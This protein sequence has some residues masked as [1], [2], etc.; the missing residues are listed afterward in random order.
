MHRLTLIL[1]AA[2]GFVT[3][4]AHAD[5][6]TRTTTGTVSGFDLAN[7]F[8]TGSQDLEGQPFSLVLHFDDTVPVDF[9]V[10]GGDPRDGEFGEFDYRGGP[11][12]GQ[13]IDMWASLTLG[14]RS[15]ALTGDRSIYGS[16][17]PLRPYWFLTDLD[18][19]GHALS[20]TITYL[21][22]NF[23][24]YDTTPSFRPIAGG[25]FNALTFDQTT[26]PGSY[27][28]AVPE[29]SEWAMLLLGFAATG[30]TLR[31]RTALRLR[32]SAVSSKA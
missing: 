29:L 8:G 7:I 23:S 26:T 24:I 13:S 32:P 15:F 12:Y 31:R 25:V 11:G 14:N 18:V 19:E 1:A 28:A 20:L 2:L 10:S 3:A 16:Y 27:T 30:Y 21:D 17:F 9:S 5:V 6:I 22:E 4:S